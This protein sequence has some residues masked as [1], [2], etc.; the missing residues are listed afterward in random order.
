MGLAAVTG[1]NFTIKGCF[2]DDYARKFEAS[3]AQMEAAGIKRKKAIPLMSK[4]YIR[5][6]FKV[7]PPLYQPFLTKIFTF[8]WFFALLWGGTM[9]VLI[10]RPDGLPISMAL[11]FTGLAGVLFGVLMALSE[12]IRKKK[13]GLGRWKD[14]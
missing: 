14:L 13:L 10:W 6:G 2:V 4:L 5:M 1:V 7:R 12:S 9:Y 3:L 8:G 11:A